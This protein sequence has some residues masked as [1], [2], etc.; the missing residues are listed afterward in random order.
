M[1]SLRIARNAISGRFISM[2]KAKRFPSASV[3]EIIHVSRNGVRRLKR[4]I[5]RYRWEQNQG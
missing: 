2:A 4:R 5:G 3:V 1:P